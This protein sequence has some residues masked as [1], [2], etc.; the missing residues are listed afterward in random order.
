MLPTPTA[1]GRLELDSDSIRSTAGQT[2]LAAAWAEGRAM[3]LEQAVV[4]ALEEPSSG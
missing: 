2:A 4:Y 1:P 3:T